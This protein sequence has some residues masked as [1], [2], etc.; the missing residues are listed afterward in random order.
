[1]KLKVLVGAGSRIMGLTLPFVV[2]GLAANILRPAWF[3]MGL[4]T[5]GL[6]AGIVFLALGLPLWLISVGQILTYVPRGKLITTGPFAL[7]AH[8]LYSSVGLLVIPGLGFLLDS[9]LGAALGAVL[10]VISRFHTGR[11][12][13]I[14][15]RIF[16]EEYP[17]YRSRVVFPWL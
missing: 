6:I 13:E 9:W 15:M 3:A 12:E 7:M 4:G 10:Y 1:M 16:P 5:P 8:P 11:E 17:S 14:L 2:V